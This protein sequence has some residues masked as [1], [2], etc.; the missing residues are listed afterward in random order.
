MNRYVCPLL[1]LTLLP[2]AGCAPDAGSGAE[3][4]VT[5]DADPTPVPEAGGVPA[6]Y[7]VRLDSGDPDVSDF[8]VSGSDGAFEFQTGPA[9]IYYRVD[10]RAS[11]EFTIGATFT[12]IEAP[13]DHREGMGLFFGG[14]DLEGDAH[15]YSYF[16][17]RADGHY[18]IKRRHGEGTSNVSDGW[19]ASD[20]VAVSTG[21]GDVTNALVVTVAGDRVHFLVNGEEVAAIPSDQLD[22]DGVWGLRI[23]HN[24]RVNVTGW[25]QETGEGI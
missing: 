24:L 12:E 16:L 10:Q 17:V 4:A 21:D 19:I 23:N 11:S 5:A 15:A 9:G 25:I 3:A 2:L 1:L 22:T 7:S 13:A 8:Q 6:G 18:L 14:T 20:A